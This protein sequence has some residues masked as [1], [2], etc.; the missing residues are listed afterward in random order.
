MIFWIKTSFVFGTPKVAAVVAVLS[1]FVYVDDV[2]KSGGWAGGSLSGLVGP[3]IVTQVSHFSK[4]EPYD[5][6]A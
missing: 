2:K 3:F 1:V 4:D 6:N 5:V